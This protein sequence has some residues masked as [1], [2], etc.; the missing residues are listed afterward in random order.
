MGLGID[1]RIV[2]HPV[3][4]VREARE[5]VDTL[6]VG[7][8]LIL[9]DSLR[10]PAAIGFVGETQRRENVAPSN[11]RSSV[12]VVRPA[13]PNCRAMIRRTATQRQRVQ[14]APSISLAGAH[15]PAQ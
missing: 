7:V 5:S 1:R 13:T 3:V 6:G 14:E 2:I 12:V 15:L 4:L 11:S 9:G 8:G 10:G